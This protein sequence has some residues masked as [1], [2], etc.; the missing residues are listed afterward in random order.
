[1]DRAEA[2]KRL[3]NYAYEYIN[4]GFE[5]EYEAVKMAIAALREQE[6]REREPKVVEI[7]QVKNEWVSVEERLP[8]IGTEVLICDI[9]DT[10]NYMDVWSLEDDEDGDA[11]WED[12]NGNWYSVD[13][14]THWM[15]LPEPPKEGADHE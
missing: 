2:I 10:R 1:M 13:E 9:F 15:P 4:D 3:T 7:D 11:V 5:Q 14:V 6:Q 8:E 12:K